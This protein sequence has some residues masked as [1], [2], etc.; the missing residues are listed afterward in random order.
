MSGTVRIYV[1][2]RGFDAPSGGS[3]LDAL[4]VLDQAEAAAVRRGDKMIT[5]S[6]G[7][8]T[9]PGGLVYNGAI[10][11]VVKARGGADNESGES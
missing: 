9:E 4:Q 6:R 5:D 1:N 10:F 8:P 2:G 11:R 7:I 3:I